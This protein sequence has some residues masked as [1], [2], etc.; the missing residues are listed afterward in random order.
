MK[1]LIPFAIS[2]LFLGGCQDAAPNCYRIESEEA[3]LKKSGCEY[4]YADLVFIAN[5]SALIPAQELFSVWDK[6]THL[7]PGTNL[8]EQVY[9]VGFCFNRKSEKQNDLVGN[10]VDCMD[11]YFPEACHLNPTTKYCLM[12]GK[13]MYLFY[14]FN[15]YSSDLIPSEWKLCTELGLPYD[16]IDYPFGI[17]YLS[18][19]WDPPLCGNGIIEW[20]EQCDGDQLGS[21][22]DCAEHAALIGAG[23]YTSGEITCSAKCTWDFGGCVSSAP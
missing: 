23:Q 9:H 4:K 12:L 6:S 18:P 13:S 1:C 11:Q 8:T 21:M 22:A 20:G 16:T 10:D 17:Q 2:W 15:G 14:S 3:C 7:F 5:G 19:E